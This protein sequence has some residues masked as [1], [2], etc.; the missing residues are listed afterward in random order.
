M[1]EYWTSL[2]ILGVVFMQNTQITSRIK[3]LCRERKVSIEKLLRDCKIRRSLMY[4]MEKRDKTPS[5]KVVNDIADYFNVSV[6]Y[7]LDRTD[8]PEVNQ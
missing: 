7:L 4:D 2:H 8:K 1:V 5:V 6:D 3:L